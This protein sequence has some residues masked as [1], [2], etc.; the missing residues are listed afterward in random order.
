VRL[1]VVMAYMV[2]VMP[3][4]RFGGIGGEGDCGGDRD[5]P[6]RANP[7]TTRGNQ[8]GPKHEL[9]RP[10]FCLDH[11]FVRPNYARRPGELSLFKNR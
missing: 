6:E 10:I 8:A 5:K 3:V 7:P 4:A 2:S 1:R 9:S 11:R